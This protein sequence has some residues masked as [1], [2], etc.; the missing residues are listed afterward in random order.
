LITT[1]YLCILVTYWRRCLCEYGACELSLLLY[2]TVAAMAAMPC[3]G[4]QAHILGVGPRARRTVIK[5]FLTKIKNSK[6]RALEAHI[7]IFLYKEN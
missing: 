2:R 4:D 5:L 3:G 6:C 1:H 7:I